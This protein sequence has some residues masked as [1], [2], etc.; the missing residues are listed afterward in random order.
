ME[1]STPFKGSAAVY[2][3]IS[4]FINMERGQSFKSFRLD[5]MSILAG[6]TGH[7][8]NCAPAIHTAGSKGKGTVTGMTASILNADGICC[9]LYASPHVIDFRERISMGSNF[10]SEKIYETA[11]DE[12]RSAVLP[13]LNSAD[14]AYV[15][16]NSKNENGEEPTFFE[17]MTLWFFL[18]SRISKVK[19]MAVETGMGGRLDATNIMNPLVSVITL[20]ELEH[21]EYLGNTIAEIAGEKAGIIKTGRPAVIAPQKDEALEVFRKKAGQ[22]ASPLYYF[23]EYGDIK[24]LR[25]QKDGTTFSLR[26]KNP[27]NGNS[28]YLE[29]LRL[30]LPGRIPAE[31]AGLAILAAITA[32]PQITTEAIKKGLAEFTIPA[33]FERLPMEQD[34]ILDGAHTPRSAEST[35]AT[36]TQLYGEGGILI[37]G[38]AAGKDARTMASI[39]TPHFARIIITTPGSFKKSSP[40]DVYGIFEKSATGK[41]NGLQAA[42]S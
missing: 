2:D 28:L 17:L 31:N 4:G 22:T 27:V 26:L 20:I 38:C 23:P 18:C 35:V 12:L 10:F 42:K 36:F 9:S 30:T 19:A 34:F 3:W 11:G 40:E 13:L 6:L 7:P 8:E 16:F 33:R 41:Q 32:F 37:F 14:P 39:F 1:S 15:L 5:R 21:T 25:L 24:N 29:D